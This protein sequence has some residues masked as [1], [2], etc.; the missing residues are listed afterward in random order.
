MAAPCGA[1]CNEKCSIGASQ[2]A[3]SAF[4]D[5]SSPFYINSLRINGHSP[6]F[7]G[8]SSPFR[9]NYLRSRGNKGR[10]G[11]V[12]SAETYNGLRG[13]CCRS[14]CRPTTFCV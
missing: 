14:A 3:A 4:G 13:D 10:Y 6:P 7:Y 1:S 8:K 11:D 5:R 2:G 12:V 9:G